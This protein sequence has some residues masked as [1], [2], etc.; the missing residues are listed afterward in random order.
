MG[1]KVSVERSIRVAERYRSDLMERGILILPLN[2]DEPEDNLNPF[3]KAS[4][5]LQPKKGFGEK[6]LKG[7]KE[8]I[9][10]ITEEESATGLTLVCTLI[11]FGSDSFLFPLIKTFLF[12][13]SL[14][15]E[16]KN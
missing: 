11:C 6:A 2:W 16:Q 14:K 8:E 15:K 7:K 13:M 1:D 3:Q 9:A 5:V 10:T 4:V 12:R